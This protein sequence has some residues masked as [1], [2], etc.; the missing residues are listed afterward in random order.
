[1]KVR[2][3]VH[4]SARILGVVASG[5]N[6][7]DHEINDAISALNMMLRQWSSSRDYVY[8][9]EEIELD[10]SQA[11]N[12][13]DVDAK[14]LMKQIKLKYADDQECFIDV[15]RDIAYLNGVPVVIFSK[16]IAGY[17]VK[18][19]KHI[20]AKKLILRSLKAPSFPLKPLDDIE[21]P[22]VNFR[23]IKYALA[24]ELASEYQ[25]AV[26]ADINRNYTQ[27]M[28]I[29]KRVNTTSV[30]AKPERTLMSISYGGR[31]D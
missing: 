4:A 14:L 22:D 18:V 20:G 17:E 24:V 27:A 8:A 15:E 1:M 10:L 3:L 23:A 29:M 16:G 9:A 13:F 12:V 2:E 6:M 26:T 25:M 31:Y 7:P 30:R 28:R 21:M 11:G 5:E 19:P